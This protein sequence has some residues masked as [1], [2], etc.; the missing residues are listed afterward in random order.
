M[1]VPFTWK[2][3]GWFMIGWSPEFVIGQTRALHYFGEDLVAYRD[4][5]GELHL[6]EAHCKH[7]G[8]HLGHG[9]KVVQDR[10]ECPFHGWQW[11][12]DG[13]NK[14][15]PYQPD[16]PNKALR[17]RVYPVREQHGCV[18]AWH[19]PDGAE[20]HWEMPDIFGKFPQFTAGPQDYYRAYPEFSR[21]L[22]GEPV[23][24]QIVAENA[25]DS[26]HFQY[27]HHAT[28]T[29]R[30]LDWKMV[31]QEWQFVAGWPDERSEDPE[32]MALRFHSHLFGLGGA[33]SIFEGVQQHRLIFT[34]TPVDE[35]RSDLFYSIWWPRKQGDTS[36]IPPDDVRA[37][38]EK[39]FLGTV[40]DDLEIWRVSIENKSL[41]TRTF[42]VFSYVELCLGHALVDL[43]N[44]PNDQHFNLVSYDEDNEIIFATK[45]YW[46]TYRGA[47][48][49]Q[50]N[51]AW[52]KCV[53]FASSLPVKGF[54]GKK[55][56]FIGPWRSESDPAAVEEGC[57]RNTEITA[58]D[59]CAALQS[60]IKIKAGETLAVVEAMKMEMGLRA[61]R[62]ATVK[63][64]HVQPG[65]QV[66]AKDLLL[67][68]AD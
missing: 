58:G 49:K 20:P 67:E 2:V 39:V 60:K 46:V 22:E 27:V 28:V 33:I 43:I 1:K 5:D 7:M 29:P 54:D 13:C 31:D 18:F 45:N 8:A 37:H 56:A 50:P 52:D 4:T 12:P 6:M 65:V 41:K 62:A 16:R 3:T 36:D 57:C 34:C 53:Y 66:E 17:L 61:E 14:F 47:T 32:Q 30:V 11:G 35:G 59:A 38:V 24:P 10:V 26:A 9:G 25:A 63:A 44:Q 21:R 23:H 42:D 48:V 64:I 15:I 68:F 55:D 19:H 51:Q 40:W